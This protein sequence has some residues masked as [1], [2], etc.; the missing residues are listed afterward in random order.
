MSVSYFALV[1]HDVCVKHQ[2]LVKDSAFIVTIVY[3]SL[4]YVKT[5]VAELTAKDFKN[6]HLQDEEPWLIDF[7]APWCGHC[8]AFA[9]KFAMASLVRNN[10]I[11]LL[12][13]CGGIL[14]ILP[15][16]FCLLVYMVHEKLN[17]PIRFYVD[18]S[19][20]HNMKCWTRHFESPPRPFRYLPCPV[21]YV[22]CSS[23]TDAMH[24]RRSCVC[25]I[26]WLL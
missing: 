25:I 18:V 23:Y 3:Y 5:D 17:S 16:V 10:S 20:C 8:H 24:R 21:A 15:S 11:C 4:R 6:G 12:W 22:Q 7:F 1:A 2:A 13:C 19:F 14:I 9:P 26:M